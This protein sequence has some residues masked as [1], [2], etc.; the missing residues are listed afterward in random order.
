MVA[1]RGAAGGDRIGDSDAIIRVSDGAAGALQVKVKREGDD[2]TLR[3]RAEDLAMRRV[4]AESLPELK[5]EPPEGE[6]GR[7]R[8]RGE[9]GRHRRSDAGRLHLG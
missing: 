4:M 5:H 9:G 8:Y 7:G 3:V 6:L 1:Q 2:L